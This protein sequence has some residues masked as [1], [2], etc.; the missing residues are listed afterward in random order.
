MAR[1]GILTFHS[2]D[3]YGAV[4]QT[5]ALS[6]AIRALGHEAEVIDYRPLVA[7]RAYN[8][9]GLRSGRPVQKLMRRWKFRKFRNRYLPLSKQCYLTGEALRAESAG[10]R[11]RDCRQR[12]GLERALVSRIRSGVLSWTSCPTRI[13]VARATRHASV[14]RTIS[15][16]TA[17]KLADC[18]IDSIT[19]R[20]EICTARRSSEK[21]TGSIAASRTRPHV[22]GKLRR[23]YDAADGDEAVHL[24]L[25]PAAR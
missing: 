2:A 7:R 9:L 14:R 11:L 13:V 19:C 17:M 20:C 18:S 23:T 15:E 5:Y 24:R 25:Q 10:A 21:F 6:R 4:L 22:H 3:N 16:R 8:R 12:P 1:A